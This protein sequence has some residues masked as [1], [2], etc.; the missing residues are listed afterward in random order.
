MTAT[1]VLGGVRSGKSRYAEQLL[2]EHAEVLVVAPGYPPDEGDPQWAERVAAHRARRPQSWT[3]LESLDLA[4][5]IRE[6]SSPVLIDCL[7][8]W[9]TRFIDGIG[10]WENPREASIAVAWAE[11][12]LP[13]IN[14]SRCSLM[15]LQ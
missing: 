1:L 3:T 7:G 6:A 14:A 2:R 9:L 15:S 5:A 11:R 4:G 8:L 10:G 12:A 13:S